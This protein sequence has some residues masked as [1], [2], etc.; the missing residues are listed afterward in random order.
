[1]EN[2]VRQIVLK[3]FDASNIAAINIAA[4]RVIVT[5]QNINEDMAK[6]TN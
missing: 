5:L 1:M 2:D 4:N 3:Y 6:P